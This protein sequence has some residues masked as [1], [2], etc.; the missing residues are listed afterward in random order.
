MLSPLAG[1]YFLLKI[2]NNTGQNICPFLSHSF[3]TQDPTQSI[4]K[5]FLTSSTYETLEHQ[6]VL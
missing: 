3:S 6:M 2:P 4:A 1:F 5:V